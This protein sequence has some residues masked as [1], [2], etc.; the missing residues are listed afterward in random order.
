MNRWMDV[1]SYFE[2]LRG[3]VFYYIHKIDRGI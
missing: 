2:E 1:N 3:P